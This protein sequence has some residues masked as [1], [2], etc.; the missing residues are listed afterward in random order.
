MR[1]PVE[2]LLSRMDSHP[3]E[4][5]IEPK[6]GTSNKFVTMINQYRRF[7]TDEEK[8]AIDEKLSEVN[9]NRLL[10]R[11]MTIIFPPQEVEELVEESPVFD[12]QGYAN[13]M[14]LNKTQIL[15]HQK[16]MEAELKKQMAQVEEDNDYR[17]MIERLRLEGYL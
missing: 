7:F 14:A 8:K 13:Q 9:L 16:F 6:S 15:L 10:E 12:S 2:L 17:K 1:Q 11:T 3:D 4:F 5:L